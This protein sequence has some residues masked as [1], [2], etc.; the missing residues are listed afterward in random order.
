MIKKHN[1][2][3]DGFQDSINE[4]RERLEQ[5]LVAENLPEFKSKSSDIDQLSRAIEEI[6]AE[7]AS[8][9]KQIYEL[10]KD[11]GSHRKPADE[12]NADIDAYFGRQELFFE[13]K[14]NG[15]QIYRNGSLAQ[16]LSEGEKTV[17]AL[18]YFLKTLGDKSFSLKEGIVVIDDPIAS[19]DSVALFRA[20]EF[21]KERI[22]MVGQLFIMTHNHSFFRQVKEWFNDQNKIDEKCS[23]HFYMLCDNADSTP[24]SSCI[25]MLDPLLSEYESEFRYLH[26]LGL[27]KND[28][29]RYFEKMLE[30]VNK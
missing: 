5:S 21:I 16:N 26:S 22:K 9:S 2:K 27:T 24:R 23:K 14:E 20:F 17:I 13:T 10:E 4:A 7:N 3:T 30:L 8:F 19:L 6:A 29:T 12:L 18:L 28:G 25:S 15:Y 11:I 1:E